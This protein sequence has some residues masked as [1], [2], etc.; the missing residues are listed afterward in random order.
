MRGGAR[1]R[2][3]VA[4]LFPLL[5]SGAQAFAAA[6]PRLSV[7]GRRLTLDGQPRRAVGVNYYDVFNRILINPEDASSEE[8]LRLLGQRGVPFVR[9]DLS[10]YWPVHL[11][12]ARDR[13][14]EYFARLDRVV[15]AA[16][17]AGVGLVPTF[18]WTTFAVPDMVGEPVGAWADKGSATRLFMRDW[19]DAVVRRYRDSPALL[20]WEFGNE[21]NLAV[22]LPNAAEHRPPVRPALGT[23]ASRS[24]A[25]DLTS[26][27]IRPVWIE[28]AE[29]VRSLDATRPISTGHSLVRSSQWHQRQWALG[30]LALARAWK[31]DT[32]AQAREITDFMNP[33]PFDMV[34]IHVYGEEA[35]RWE[36][37]VR[38]SRR[39]VFVGEFGVAGADDGRFRVMLERVRSMPISAVWVFDRKD[40]DFSFAPDHPRSWVFDAISQPAG[41]H[42]A[43]TPLP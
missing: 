20:A 6:P 11:R 40:D 16:E 42:D 30:R 13:P 26:E 21:W 19:V 24:P 36:E 15:R 4:L 14:E 8:G 3:A 23:P 18:F 29:L 10:G 5:F 9:F 2:I 37:V 12:L 33:P 38:G 35:G 27:S 1:G 41:L 7:E 28:F 31:E 32:P 43:A 17:E 25:D 22:D 34:S 39:P